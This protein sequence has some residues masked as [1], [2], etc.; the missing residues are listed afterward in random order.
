MC[1]C[2]NCLE[3]QIYPVLMTIEGRTKTFQGLQMA[4]GRTLDIIVQKIIDLS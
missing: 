3:N 4:P 2:T 1:I